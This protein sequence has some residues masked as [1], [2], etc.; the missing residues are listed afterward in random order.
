MT[1][2]QFPLLLVQADEGSNVMWSS[3]EGSSIMNTLTNTSNIIP[4]VLPQHSFHTQ[5]KQFSM[6]ALAAG[7]GCGRTTS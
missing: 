6:L 3:T 5:Q 1:G 4:T 7:G 2:K